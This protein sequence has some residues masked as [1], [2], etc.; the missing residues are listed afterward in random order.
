[1]RR[2]YHGPRFGIP[3]ESM[4]YTEVARHHMKLN[5]NSKTRSMVKPSHSKLK[6]NEAEMVKGIG[7]VEAVL[8]LLHL[9]PT[10][11]MEKHSATRLLS[12]RLLRWLRD[13]SSKTR[14]MVKPSH[15]KLK[16]NE[17][18][19]VKGIGWVEAEG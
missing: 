7:W 12:Y 6:M 18:E 16:M 9:P 15:S 13:E 3:V 8:S 11:F 1:M 2:F 14:S 5:G 10:S 17:A 19:M 4:L